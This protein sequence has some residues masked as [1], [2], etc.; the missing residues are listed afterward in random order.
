MP[1]GLTAPYLRLLTEHL[2]PAVYRASS[3]PDEMR[4]SI[5]IAVRFW[6][7]DAFKK[8]RQPHIRRSTFEKE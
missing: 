1:N 6:A 2:Q 3:W 8:C 7:S 5:R 4:R